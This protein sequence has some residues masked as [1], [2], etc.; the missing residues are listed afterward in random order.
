MK[1]VMPLNVAGAYHSRLME[2]ARAAFAAY[3]AA[4]RFPPRASRVLTNTTG[5]ASAEPARSS[6]A[7]VQQVVSSVL[8]EDCMRAAAAAGP[9]VLGTRTGRGARR[10]R[11]AHRK[12]L[13]RQI[14]F[15]E[16][17]DVTA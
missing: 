12:I 11:A 2:P 5:Q 3:L 17:A 6:A 13:G 8:W 16:F 1:K 4:C 7:L 14:S 10:P 9:R 15:A